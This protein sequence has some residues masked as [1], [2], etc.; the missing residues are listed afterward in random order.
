MLWVVFYL[1][2]MFVVLSPSS[3]IAPSAIKSISIHKV[4]GD[5]FQKSP[6]VLMHPKDGC[7]RSFWDSPC[8]TIREVLRWPTTDCLKNVFLLFRC[9]A[10]PFC[11]IGRTAL[12]CIWWKHPLKV[13]HPISN[14]NVTL[15]ENLNIIALIKLLYLEV[16]AGIFFLPEICPYPQSFSMLWLS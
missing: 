12:E 1:L 15:S 8:P 14:W 6:L 10:F 7:A 4:S 13:H 16:N 2:F 5:C 9:L 11:C 3:S